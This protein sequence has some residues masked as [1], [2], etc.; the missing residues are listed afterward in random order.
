[1]LKLWKKRVNPVYYKKDNNL[2][3]KILLLKVANNY[4]KDYKESKWENL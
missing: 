1:M 2:K 4:K 3:R